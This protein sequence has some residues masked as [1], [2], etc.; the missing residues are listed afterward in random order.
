MFSLRNVDCIR[1]LC[2][3]LL[4]TVDK[5]KVDFSKAS[6]ASQ[7]MLHTPAE[8][9]PR[10]GSQEESRRPERSMNLEADA[11]DLL[12]QEY[13]DHKGWVLPARQWQ[14][15]AGPA[16]CSPAT[17]ARCRLSSPRAARPGRA[18]SDGTA[19][20]R[21]LSSVALPVCLRANITGALSANIHKYVSC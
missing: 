4:N 10:S 19:P 6:N 16:L 3:R 9:L 17:H 18:R 1:K 15:A 12:E 21:W 5:A 7:P 14:G 8:L 13:R 11:V 2:R 20:S